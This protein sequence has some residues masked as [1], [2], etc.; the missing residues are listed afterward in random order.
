MLRLSKQL[1]RFTRT[2]QRSGSA[3]SAALSMTFYTL[4]AYFLP[5]FALPTPKTHSLW[6]ASSSAIT[7]TSK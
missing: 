5:T 4:F 2:V 1:Y 7:T 3:A 6:P